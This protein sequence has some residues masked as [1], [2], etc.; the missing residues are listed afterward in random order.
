MVTGRTWILVNS[1]CQINKL[2]QNE[3]GGGFN[4][5]RDTVMCGDR[6]TSNKGRVKLAEPCWWWMDHSHSRPL[7]RL[8]FLTYQ[9][10]GSGEIPQ[11]TEHF[12]L[13]LDFGSFKLQWSDELHE[14]Q[15]PTWEFQGSSST[16]KVAGFIV[17]GVT[18]SRH[19]YERKTYITVLPWTSQRGWI[20]RKSYL[21]AVWSW[22]WIST[23]IKPYQQIPKKCLPANCWLKLVLMWLHRGSLPSKAT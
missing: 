21:V 7:W 11:T 12:F 2:Q 22:A 6:A 4:Q 10:V 17:L 23:P 3:G 20:P 19:T 16:E 9:G 13:C 1:L 14:S 15:H 18:Y 8:R 5:D